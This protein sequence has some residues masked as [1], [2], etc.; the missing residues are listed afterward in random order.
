MGL[1]RPRDPEQLRARH[2][3]I[4]ASWMFAKTKIANRSW[5]N[6]LSRETFVELSDYLL[7]PTVLN[8]HLELANVPQ[9]PWHIVLKYGLEIRKKS[10]DLIIYQTPQQP[11]GIDSSLKSAM[12]DQTLRQRHF[13]TP[14]LWADAAPEG[15]K[16]K[17]E[18]A[19]RGDGS[20]R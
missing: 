16:A 10:C 2:K 4:S 11:W 14:L 8:H 19:D 1:W 18:D 13:L 5:L 7:G 9:P 15:E 20:Q 17:A 3:L 12:N 6:D